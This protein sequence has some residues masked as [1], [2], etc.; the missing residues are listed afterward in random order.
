MNRATLARRYAPLAAVIAVQL[1][2]I[3][4]VPSRAPS[5]IV[6]ADGGSGGSGAEGG[7]FDENGE[8]ASE[9]GEPGTEGDGG[10]TG[11]TGGS[12]GG[13]TTGSAGGGGTT[14]GTGGTAGGGGA[15]GGGGGGGGGGLTGDTSHCVDG[16]QFDPKIFYY[17]PKCV[18]K[19]GGGNNG[20]ATY[21]G[22]TDKEIKVVVYRGKP[23]PQVDA[24]LDA[25][26]SNPPDPWVTDFMHKTV[27][28]MNQKFQFY[29]RK[30]VVREFFGK[31]DTVPPNYTCLR[32]EMRDVVRAEKPYAVL[33]PTILASPA[34]D[35]LS[36]LKVV[37]IGGQHFRNNPFSVQRRP[38]HWD[39]AI[40]G[41]VAARHVARWYCNRLH[42]NKAIFA[43]ETGVNGRD[44]NPSDIRGKTRVL[45]VISTDDPENLN[46]IK[47]VLKPE[48]AKC[49]AT[50]AHEFYYA[51]DISRAEEQ[52]RLGMQKMRESPES[53]SIMCFCDAV[54]PLFLYR[55]AQE[56][57]YFPEHIVVGIGANDTDAVG[58]SYDYG[59]TLC[60][61]CHQY[62]NAFGLRSTTQLERF[63]NNDATRLYKLMGGNCCAADKG[64]PINFD[65]YKGA[66]ADLNY[67]MLL[68]NLLQGAGP[69]LTP[70]NMQKGAFSAGLRGGFAELN[71]VHF[72]KRGFSPGNY[73]WF[74]DM[75]QVYWSQNT[76]SES[77]GN[78]SAASANAPKGSYVQI[79]GRRFDMDEYP[80]GQPPIPPAKRR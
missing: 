27:E 31:C 52:R 41:D 35:E 78:G 77:M 10:G 9:T 12:G 74:V 13:G 38:Y 23:N 22:V 43:G 57:N 6:E 54:A 7:G 47:Q 76:P 24:I 62:E 36:A 15:G 19:W 53:T 18:A 39:V 26:G 46:T 32:G 60:P 16:R 1:L 28:F 42:G 5:Q 49:G 40:P 45:G 66:I 70:S 4:T 2:I 67:Y 44:Q 65:K 58:Q 20:G 33:W 61:E 71:D 63:T 48:L 21:Q 56:Q 64:G 17:G 51:Q 11:D 30:L 73:G 68:G 59:S 29:G 75:D 8:F 34:F 79:D 14:G 25:I 50:V 3:A 80:T 55:T 37:N 69:A 72:N